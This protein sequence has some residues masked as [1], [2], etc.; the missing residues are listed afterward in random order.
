MG[1]M[2]LKRMLCVFS[3]VVE[4][5]ITH[6]HE[7]LDR[8]CMGNSYLIYGK[9]NRSALELLK[10]LARPDSKCL[11][12]TRS[13]PQN[14]KSIISQE[15][16]Q[17]ALL[18]NG[19]SG[20][21]ETIS[22]LEGLTNKI[23]RFSRQND[24]SVILLDTIEYLLIKNS[25]DQFAESLYQ[26]DDIISDDNSL[27]LLHLNPSVLDERQK[28]IIE[29]ELQLLSDLWIDNMTITDD[30]Y[31]MLKFIHDTKQKNSTASPK[32]IK[33]AMH[34][35]YTTIAKRLRLLEERDLIIIKKQGRSKTIH[36]SKKGERILN[37]MQITQQL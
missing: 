7:N 25:F 20:E 22:D 3:T 31:N 33:S 4:R 34:L 10:S 14:I 15:N 37:K 9:T 6:E 19:G 36:I 11:F 17:V 8:L 24:N 35:T 16:I 13:N 32:K 21:H 23:K 28:A 29:D 5:D 1:H 27:L 26:I 2:P 12:I 30:L 18:R